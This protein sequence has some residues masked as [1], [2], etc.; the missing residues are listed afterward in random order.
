M[1]R[2]NI[3]FII[4]YY[5]VFMAYIIDNILAKCNAT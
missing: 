5:T 3:Q 1:T 2:F 4:T